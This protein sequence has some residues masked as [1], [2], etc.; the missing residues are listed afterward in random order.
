MKKIKEGDFVRVTDRH[1]ASFGNV[2]VVEKITDNKT[3]PFTVRFADATSEYS[4]DEIEAVK[5]NGKPCKVVFNNRWGYV[6][7]PIAQPSIAAAVRFAKE[8]GWFR[9]AVYVGGK[10]V[11]QGFCND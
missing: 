1:C 2:G 5:G 3:W 9:Y 11:R 7:Q 6:S 10:L 8:S 4:G